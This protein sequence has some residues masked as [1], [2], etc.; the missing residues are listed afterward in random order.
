MFGKQ[1]LISMLAGHTYPKQYAELFLEL[2]H[3]Q[4]NNVNMNEVL[5]I[6]PEFFN[7]MAVVKIL[8]NQ[9]IISLQNAK[10]Y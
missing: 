3:Y 5:K 1:E 2:F 9:G 6:A 10:N 4:Q 8:T 7:F